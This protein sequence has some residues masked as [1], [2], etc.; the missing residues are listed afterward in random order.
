MFLLG[1]DM[2][3]VILQSRAPQFGHAA[4][5][6]ATRVQVGAETGRVGF[7]NPKAR[8]Y[9]L[10]KLTAPSRSCAEAACSEECLFH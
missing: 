5:G 2:T 8:R 1:Y 6:S 3:T 7:S 4:E 10:S 9:R